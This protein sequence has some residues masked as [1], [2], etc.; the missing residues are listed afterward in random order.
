[1]R[2]R[3]RARRVKVRDCHVDGPACD[4][5]RA[6]HSLCADNKQRLI[7]QRDFMN[8]R[9]RPL[10]LSRL[11]MRATA[12]ESFVTMSD[13]ANVDDTERA[14]PVITIANRETIAGEL[15]FRA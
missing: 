1:M 14:E 3:D 4:Q 15:S 7:Q 11:A 9:A 8:S 13:S 6:A 10:A 5:F 2:T 12:L